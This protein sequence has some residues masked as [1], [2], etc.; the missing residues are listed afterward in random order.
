M[1]SPPA[2]PDLSA[3][4]R[5]PIHIPGSIQ[6]FGFLLALSSDSLRIR[7]VSANIGDYVDLP[8]DRV[9]GCLL[10]DILPDLPGELVEAIAATTEGQAHYM[11]LVPL[12]LSDA[13]RRFH[14]IAHRSGDL[15]ILEMEE[16]KA[17][18]PSSF[19]DVYP[20][21]RSFVE[22]LHQADDVGALCNLAAQEVRRITGTDR[23]MVYRFDDQWHGTVVAEDRN[24]QLSSYLDLRFPSSDIPAQARAL[25]RRNR[26]RMIADASYIPV[27]L[28][29]LP[30]DSQEP[31]DLSLSVLRAVSPVHLEYMRNMGTYASMSVSL[32]CDGRLWGLITCHN[33]TP[34]HIPFHVRAACDHLGQVLSLQLS[35]RERVT[36]S[37]QR[38]ELR[39]IQVQ[40]LAHMAESDTFIDGLVRSE[41]ELLR[42]TNSHGAAILFGGDRI[43]LGRTPSGEEVDALVNWLVEKGER[44]LYA[45][46]HLPQEWEEAGRFKDEATG[47]LAISISQIHPA[48]V[49]WFRP[50]VVQTVKWGGEPAKA[51]D[52]DGRIHPRKSFDVW[53]QTVSLTSLPWEEAEKAA[54]Q[55]LRSAIVGIVLR[56][57]EELAALTAELRRSNKELEAFSYSVSHDLRAPFRHIVGFAELLRE[58]EGERVSPRGRHYIDSIIEAAFSA[59]TLVDNLLSFS[60]MGRAALHMRR[61]DMNNMVEE[62][63]HRLMTDL[64]GRSIR[65][66]VEPL[67]QAYADPAMIRLVLQNLLSNALKFTRDRDPA[68]ITVTAAPAAS[69][70]GDLIRFEVRDNG[71]GFDM[72]YVDKLFGVFQRLHHVE[73]FEGTGIGLAN[74]RRI[75][76]RHGGRT[77]AE[78]EEGKGASFFFT[79]PRWKGE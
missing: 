76:E 13:G 24:E 36:Q 8:P 26:L 39:S 53:K 4:A 9:L 78:G 54:A 52:A 21:V 23:V 33:S 75:V 46:D 70:E 35:A 47:V 19:Q 12:H 32:L 18:A 44:E 7:H 14:A 67:G 20:L 41:P 72:T 2:P 49:L 5:E 51:I 50:E 64:D 6:P 34:L 60:Q 56:K 22:T 30:E 11:R 27:P 57:A 79:L 69:E 3:C 38:N 37:E 71:V 61:T 1:T 77:W 17:I 45:T 43:L 66:N 42:L 55:E 65:W 74:V 73:E 68:E 16:E 62:A 59:G 28:L 58:R 63:R 25:Y 10:T 40:L 31:L 48:Y 29:G 15:I